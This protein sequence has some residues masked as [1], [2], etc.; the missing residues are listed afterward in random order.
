M[1]RR[2][3]RRTGPWCRGVSEADSDKKAIDLVERVGVAER[4]IL[5]H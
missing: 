2:R 3:R 4:R 5:T 1:R